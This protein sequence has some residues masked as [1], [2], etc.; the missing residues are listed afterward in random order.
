MVA[1]PIKI[2]V[3][4]CGDIS[5]T[6][7]KNLP[8]FE[9]LE[10]TGCADI[11]REKAE[12]RAAEFGIEAMDVQELLENPGIDFIV[13]LT[14]PKA[15]AFVNNAALKSGKHVYTEKPLSTSLEEAKSSLLIA[16][17]HDLRLGSAPD[18]FLG[19]GIQTCRY[20]IDSGE[21]GFPV[22]AVAFMAGHGM[23]TWHPD[24]EFFYKTGGGPMLD[25]GPY[26]LT[27][28]VSL[29]GPIRRISGSV[30]ISFPERLVTSQMNYGKR[31]V[32]ETPTHISGVM[33]FANGTI[34]TI[35]TS[36]DVWGSNLPR[37]E[38]YGSEGSL[39]VPDPNTFGGP[40]R[41]FK[42]GN[43][44]QE[45]DLTH[46]YTQ[47]SRGLGLA[48]MV[49]A[50]QTGRPHRANGDLAFHVL[51]AMLAFEKSS[52][53]GMHHVLESSCDRPAPFPKGLIDGKIPI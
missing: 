39:S 26:Y 44:W 50:I 20:L 38:I 48:D 40:V 27:A 30:K 49:K 18:T 2:G 33:E 10:I 17:H 42:P 4:G 13:N 34:G 14:V 19:G 41:L 24:P 16:R 23:E 45:V 53:T 9:G 3:I 51:E 31:I 43:G 47:N 5:K 37:I 35:I 15:H 52:R 28:L 22:A 7:L 1:K 6:Y 32:V 36:F 46:G 11:V 21:I 12:N 25:I 8:A 29:L